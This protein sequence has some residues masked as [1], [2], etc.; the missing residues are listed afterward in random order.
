[1]CCYPVLCP[2]ALMPAIKPPSLLFSTMMEVC[3]DYMV[4]CREVGS[5][6]RMLR[7]TNEV[8]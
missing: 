8:R 5:I 4:A 1:M 3:S 7:L 2:L 6:M